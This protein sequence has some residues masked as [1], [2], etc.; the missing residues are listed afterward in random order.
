MNT[1]RI[2]PSPLAVAPGE[3][4]QRTSRFRLFLGQNL[5]QSG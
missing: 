4:A 2:A 1:F 3:N 5:Q